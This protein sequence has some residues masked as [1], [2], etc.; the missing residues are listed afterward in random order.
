MVAARVEQVERASVPDE[1]R[2]HP[3]AAVLRDEPAPDERRGELRAGGREAKVA[4]EGRTQTDARAGAVDR[5]DDRL[6]DRRREPDGPVETHRA[7]VVRVP[8]ALE[9]VHV[10]PRAPA[11]AGGRHD[12]D[13]DIRVSSGVLQQRVVAA[14]EPTGPRVEPVR[15]VE[16]ERGDPVTHFVQHDIRLHVGHAFLPV[17]AHLRHHRAGDDRAARAPGRHEAVGRPCLGRGH[18]AELRHRTRD[19]ARYSSTV[20]DALNDR[21]ARYR[22]PS[23]A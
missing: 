12:D 16:G 19:L 1:P 22:R 2:E 14:R 17:C 21:M 13:A 7:R 18:R 10:G 20:P 9:A 23:G 11:A 5:R 4:H 8:A 3:R 6:R 15:S